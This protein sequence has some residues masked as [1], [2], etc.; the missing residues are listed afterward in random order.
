MPFGH[1]VAD[2]FTYPYIKYHCAR[3][4]LPRPTQWLI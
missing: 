2:P 1:D 3:E 4:E